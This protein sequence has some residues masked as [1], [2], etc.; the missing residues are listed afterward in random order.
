MGKDPRRP[1]YTI[2]EIRSAL[3]KEGEGV[4]IKIPKEPRTNP[5][6]AFWDGKG[7]YLD[8]DNRVILQARWPRPTK[9][10]SPSW[11][12]TFYDCVVTKGMWFSQPYGKARV[13]EVL[14]KAFGIIL[15][16]WEGVPQ[17]KGE[18]QPWLPLSLLESRIASARR[19]GAA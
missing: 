13:E 3:D 11:L 15:V 17:P 16:D 12:R 1:E 18:G 6:M 14:K 9:N 19:T 4:K 2:G 8:T 7:V 10:D 5:I